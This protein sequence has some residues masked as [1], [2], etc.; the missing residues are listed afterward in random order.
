M[1]IQSKHRRPF[2]SQCA[3]FVKCRLNSDIGEQRNEKHAY[4]FIWRATVCRLA[5]IQ[6][7]LIRT[8]GLIVGKIVCFAGLISVGGVLF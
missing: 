1:H 2:V 6:A 8:S 4:G 5:V 7:A 3:L